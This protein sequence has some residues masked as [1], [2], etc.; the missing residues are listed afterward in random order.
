MVEIKEI[1]Y[2]DER[3]EFFVDQR[4]V[5]QR[6]Y[7]KLAKTIKPDEPYLS[8]RRQLLDDCG[9]EL[10]FYN[11][12]IE[13]LENDVVS[14]RTLDVY[15]RLNSELEQELATTYDKLDEAESNVAKKIFEEIE[16]FLNKAIDGWRKERKFA[17]NDRQIEMIDFR[18]GALKYCLHEI[19]ELKKKYPTE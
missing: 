2:K 4:T 13:M 9:R 6:R 5:V 12:V 15:M 3:L 8:E 14:K 16:L 18:N 11:D 10:S 1:S 17:Y 19:A 7:D